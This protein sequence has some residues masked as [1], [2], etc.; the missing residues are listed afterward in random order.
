MGNILLLYKSERVSDSLTWSEPTMTF[1][2]EM[3]SVNS[4]YRFSFVL[5]YCREN[6]IFT[7]L[8][9]MHKYVNV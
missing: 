1:D 3:C 9:L 5:H 7:I 6:E 8:L 2:T 4:A